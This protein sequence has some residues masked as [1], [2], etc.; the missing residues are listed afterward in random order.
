M[1]AVA[2]LLYLVHDFA[3]TREGLCIT[4][5]MLSG[6]MQLDFLCVVGLF[7]AAWLFG[8]MYV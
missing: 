1:S 2:L 7:V 3:K 5:A 4:F 6:Q 8:M